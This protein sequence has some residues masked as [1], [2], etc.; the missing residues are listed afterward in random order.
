MVA[1]QEESAR[2]QAWP[3][4]QQLR[5]ACA[6]PCNEVLTIC[7]ELAFRKLQSLTYQGT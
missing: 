7:F 5:G 4:K 6:P 1:R 3:R 2:Q